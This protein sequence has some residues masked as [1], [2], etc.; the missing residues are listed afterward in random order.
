[1]DMV[2]KMDHFTTAQS[3]GDEL[4]FRVVTPKC[5]VPHAA[6]HAIEDDIRL[7]FAMI[8]FYLFLLLFRIASP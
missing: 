6:T 2:R 1:M 7:K 4:S 3:L 5:C 8:R